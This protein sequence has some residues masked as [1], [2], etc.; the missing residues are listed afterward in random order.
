VGAITLHGFTA[1]AI[2]VL[3]VMTA[4]NAFNMMDGMDG[5]AGTVAIV[6][7]T[8]L[9][10]CA[11][12]GGERDV[13]VICVVLGAA[14]A[15][16]LLFNLPVRRNRRMRCFMGDAGS[17]LLG[18]ALAWVCIRITQPASGGTLEPVTAL[19]IVGLPVFEFFWTI[20]R[21][22]LH[23]RSPLRPDAG[24]FH[25]LLLRAGFGVRGSF[26]M[27][28]VLTLTLAAAGLI[29]NQLHV[30]DQVS[31]AL[32]LAAGALMVWSV[33]HARHVLRFF[34]LSA[35]RQSIWPTASARPHAKALPSSDA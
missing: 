12:L 10:V 20:L 17:T 29:L 27:F 9:A 30:T 4:I 26:M 34:P 13:A 7:L 16:F 11:G 22:L 21:R 28:L 8:A 24:H 14:T 5:L 25:H 31:L 19:W 23:G 1:K 2:T 32:L 15:G 35:R 18:S 33:H 6:A 3:F